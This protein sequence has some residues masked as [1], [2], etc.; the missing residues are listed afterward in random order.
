MA[1]EMDLD[2]V[3][4]AVEERM[5]QTIEATKHHF[6]TVR[7]GRASP[8]LVEHIRVPYYNTPTP[9]NQL[10]TISTPDPRLIVISPWDKTQTREI[11]RAIA[12]SELGLTPHSDGN[13]IRIVIPPLTEERR[14]EL[15]KVVSRMAEESRVGIRNIRRDGNEQLKKMEKNKLA[16]EDEVRRAQ[17]E[18]QELTDEYIKRIDRLLE[19]KQAEIMEV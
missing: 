17:D 12:L 8:A 18:I 15:A 10:A 2:A 19:A 4:L 13:I 11:E 3:L 16:S 1:E 6:A 5:E 9:L 7:T 14:R